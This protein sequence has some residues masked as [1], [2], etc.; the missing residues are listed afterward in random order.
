MGDKSPQKQIKIGNLTV[1]LN[2]NNQQKNR[3]EVNYDRNYYYK[4]N[5]RYNDR[6]N[7]R[8]NERNNDRYNERERRKDKESDRERERERERERNKYQYDNRNYN[9]EREKTH[10]INDNDNNRYNKKNEYD[11]RKE[12]Y[13]KNYNKSKSRSKSGSRH[14]HSYNR[15]NHS[16]SRSKSNSHHKN[17]STEQNNKNNQIENSNKNYN[18]IN[19]DN[20]VSKNNT[21]NAQINNNNMNISGNFNNNT[22]NNSN[23]PNNPTNNMGFMNPINQNIFNN[24]IN[25]EFFKRLYQMN[26]RQGNN[27]TNNI[28]VP[29]GIPVNYFYNPNLS[30]MNQL[31]KINNN[32]NQTNNNNNAQTNNQNQNQNQSIKEKEKEKEEPSNTILITD[33][34]TNIT[35]D[36]LEDIFREKCLKLQIS[37]PID[38]RIVEALNIAYII[39]P[40]VT[41]CVI[42]YNSLV[43]KKIL[44]NGKYFPVQFSPNLTS[45]YSNNRDTLTYVTQISSNTS[46]TTS[47]ETTVHEDW[48][49][50]YCDSKNF[51]RRTVC[52]KCQKPKSINCRVV[53]VIKQKK[54]ILGANGEILPNNS[55]IIQG[56]QIQYSNEGEVF[57]FLLI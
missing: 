30:N 51:S 15:N 17:Y 5:D 14:K 37:M 16:R 12:K 3:R 48:Y 33:L 35:K 55:I 18:N 42:V 24:Y 26:N 40:S 23:L 4:S 43:N 46:L 29:I 10:K 36:T 44:I 54:I 39:F 25:S 11:N 8:Y 22:N 41:S 20:N 49:C 6:N 19:K 28:I 21:N 7:D 27:N 56:K 38:I 2:P 34:D 1:K 13:N 31:N 47:M 50:V 32:N 57:I 52:F 53:P 45:K 9:L